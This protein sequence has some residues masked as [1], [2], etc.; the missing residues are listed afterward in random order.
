MTEHI[1]SKLYVSSYNRGERLFYS[2]SYIFLKY[3]TRWARQEGILEK[4]AVVI[5][6][7]RREM[8][9]ILGLQEKTINR[10]VTRL[11]KDNAI[12]LERGKINLTADQFHNIVHSLPSYRALSRNGS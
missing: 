12:T 3:L 9:E 8:S 1:A 2:S 11:E 4:Q 5:N 7:T 10:I 6:R